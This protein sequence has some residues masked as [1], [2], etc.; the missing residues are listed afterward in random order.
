MADL[1]KLLA[2]TSR[3][4][5]LSIP[6]LADPPRREVS[7]AYLLFR[8]AD[9]FE[10]A[11]RWPRNERLDALRDFADLVR[12]PSRE[13]AEKKAR[14]WLEVPPCDHAGYLQL[15]RET[16]AV[17]SELEGFTASRRKA[18]V[19]HTL[20]TVEG[21]ARFVQRADDAGNLRLSDL[22]DLQDYCYVVA[23]IVGELLTD[24]FVDAA[25]Q[26]RSIEP[27][28]RSRERAFGEGLQLV[29]ILKDADSDA[30]DGRV[31]RPPGVPRERILELSRDDLED[32][33]EYVLALHEA[34]APRG[35]VGFTA[36]P[37]LLAR[38][39]LDE[40]ERNGPGAKV[41]RL[42]VAAVVGKLMNDLE[43]GIPPLEVHAA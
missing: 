36:L 15:L 11:T 18:V 25:P 16:P 8:V 1:E 5:A 13:R 42:A 32:A 7:V 38:A 43:A 30:R 22:A 14:G 20:R 41:S 35:M 24:L 10:D 31:Y 37:V 40:V 9:T 19:L 21:M 23:G 28:L 34:Q 3:T 33:S 6:Q 12:E 39:T 27:T 29:N 2:A 17:L 26:L 4:F